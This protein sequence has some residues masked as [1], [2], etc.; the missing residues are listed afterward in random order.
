MAITQ[1]YSIITGWSHEVAALS[2]AIFG[3]LKV[4]N[5]RIDIPI[6]GVMTVTSEVL[7]QD[8]H[9]AAFVSFFQS[10]D[11]AHPQ[12]AKDQTG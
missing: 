12:Y 7:M 3:D 1:G 10:I 8:R 2:K 4:R 11:Q 9:A 5:L 6:D